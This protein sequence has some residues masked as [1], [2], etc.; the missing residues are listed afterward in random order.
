[1]HNTPESLVVS[2]FDEFGN[3]FSTLDG[4]PFEWRIFGDTYN[5][6]GDGYGV[7]RFLTW[8]ESE[9]QTPHSMALLESKGMQGYMQLISG[10]RS[11]SAVVSVS[12]LE[13]V[14]NHVQS[15]QVRLLVM[16]NAQLSPAVAY[17][18]PNSQLTLKVHVVQQTTD[19]GTFLY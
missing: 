9:Y 14:Y 7:L 15:S 11:G 19:E 1:M 16:A 12:L 5:G 4:V 18:M 6:K 8:S 17:L 10:L 13:S 2:A 3:T